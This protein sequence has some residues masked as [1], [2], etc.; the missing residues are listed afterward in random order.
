MAFKVYFLEARAGSKR[1]LR[2]MA[3]IVEVSGNEQGCVAR[4]FRFNNL[5]KSLELGTALPLTQAQVYAYG[6]KVNA[7]MGRAQYAV[8]QPST[9]VAPY[10]YIDI[11]VARYGK[12]G[13]HRIAM[14][15]IG[16]DRVTTICK[17]RPDG[18]CEKLVL[19]CGRPFRQMCGMTVVGAQYFLQEH[20]IGVSRPDGLP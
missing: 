16:V 20:D 7:H 18:I 13:Q 5:A 14:M 12:L 9:L 4:Y 8:Q 19:A 6:M 15:P 17:L 2:P 1:M 3:P 11:V 10:G